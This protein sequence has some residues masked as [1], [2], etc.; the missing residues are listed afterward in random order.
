MAIDKSLVSGSMTLLLLKLLE[1]KDM[2]GYEMI[3]ALLKQSN[4]VFELKA[5]SL[6]PLLHGLEDK[7]YL[8]SYE[9][10]V[11]GKRRKYYHLTKFGRKKSIEKKEEW[12]KYANA[13]TKVLGGTVYAGV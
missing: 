2:Y 6:Y 3:E 7:G 5:G 4:H 13:V 8:D 11:A 9:K 1:D 10:E 12:N